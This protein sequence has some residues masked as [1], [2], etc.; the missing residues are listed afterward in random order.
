L[1]TIA[2]SAICLIP[3]HSPPNSAQVFENAH[4]MPQ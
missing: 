3:I 4:T 1:A 2:A